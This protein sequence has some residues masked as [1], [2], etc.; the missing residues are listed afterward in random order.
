MITGRGADAAGRPCLR[1]ALGMRG[2]QPTFEGHM[3][4]DP[5]PHLVVGQSSHE[6]PPCH[7]YDTVFKYRS[8]SQVKGGF[9]HDDGVRLTR[10]QS[11]QLTRQALVEAAA[12]VFAQKGFH[13][14]SL[15]EIAEAAGFTRGAIYSNFESKEE[16]LLAVLDYSIDRQLEAVSA[17]VGEHGRGDPVADAMAGA[18]AWESAAPLGGNWAALGL[19]LRLSAMRN[20]A[21]RK[22][23]AESERQT[24]EKVARLIEQEAVR[25]GAQLRIS[26]RD[27]ADISRAAIDG[28]GQLAAIDEEDAPRY[29]DLVEKLF[30]LLAEVILQ[31]SPD[32]PR[33]PPA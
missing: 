16:L 25:R 32:P 29:R 15:E 13:G 8:V 31:P 24:G 10:E 12:G 4:V 33:P 3:A 14:S 9:G 30:V 7:E 26:P 5:F 6:L 20:P 27:F 11:R 28:L 17:V 18:A 2:S 22:R 21:V 19:E 1:G 23:L